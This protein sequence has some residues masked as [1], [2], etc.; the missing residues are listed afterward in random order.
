MALMLAMF[1]TTIS[2]QQLAFPGAQGWGRFAT[3]GRGGSV[4]HVTNL[5]DSGS[6]SLRDAVSQP[7]RIVVFDVAGVINIES[8][9][10]FMSNITVAGQTAPGDGITVYGDGTSCSGASNVIIRYMRFR[11]GSNA[12]SEDCGGLSNGQNMIFDHCSFSWAK[13]ENFSINWDN[14]GTK[15]QNITIQNSIIGQGLMQ[16]SAGGLIQ[17]CENITMYRNLLCDNKTRNFKVKG[18]HQYV[19]NIVYNWQSY[20]YEMGGESAG[21]SFANVEGNLFIN[22]PQ[23]SSSAN[24]FAG[25]N[26]DFHY[27]GNDNWQDRNKDGVFNPELFTG[28]GGGDPVSAP[29]DYPELEKWAGNTLIDNLLPDVGASLPY[30]DL[31]DA[32][33]VNE[34]L[35][36]G[37]EGA[38]I[39]KETLLPIG[40]PTSW[41]W[42]KGSKPADSDGDGMPDEWE[43][44]NGTN[45]NSNDAMTIA[46]NGYANIEN[47]INSITRTDRQYYLRAPMLLKMLTSTLNSL[48]ATW[49]DFSDNEEGFIIEMKKNGT[50]EEVGRTAAGVSSYT[51]A[52][53][54]LQPGT[55]YDIRVCAYSGPTKS[56][57]T[58]VVTMKT[59]P[60]QAEIVDAETFDGTGDGDWLIAPEEDET[61]TLGVATPKNTVVVRSD[62]HVTIDGSGYISG[63]ASLNKTG[64]GTLTIASNQQYEGPT[65]LHRGIYEFS[66]LK[67]GGVASGLGKSLEFAQNWVMDGGIYKYTGGNT[68]TNRSAKLSNDTELNIAQSGAVVTM[69]GSIE[70]TGNLEI[71]G[72]GRLT[73]NSE[74]FFKFDGNLV[75]SGSEV[76]LNSKA[77]SDAGIGSAKKLVLQG[78]KFTTVGMNESSATYNFPIEVVSGTTSTVDFDLWNTNKCSVSGT[79]TLVWNVHYLREYIEGNWDGF[80]GHLVVNG[81]GKANQSQFAV[82]NGAGVKN[83]TI[84][85]KGT[86]SITGGKNASTFYLGGLSGD[87]GTALSGFNVKAAG[88]GTWVVGGANTDETFNG[89]IDDYDQAHSHPGKTSIEKQGTGDWLLTGKNTY[90][91]TTVISGGRLIVN[92][93]HSGSGAITVKD[94]AT[95]AGTGTLMGNVKFENGSTL[96]ANS[97]VS[98]GKS[99]T[100][101][102]TVT[103]N[104]GV[105][106]KLGDGTINSASSGTTYQVFKGAAT[107]SFNS[108]IPETPGNGLK[109]DTSALYSSGV[110]K[111]IGEDEEPDAPDE[112]EPTVETYSALLSWNSMTSGS[113]DNNKKNRLTGNKGGTAEGFVMDLTGNA[114][115]EYGQYDQYSVEYN[116]GKVTANSIKTSNGAANTIYVPNGYEAT[117][118]TL[119]SVTNVATANRTSYWKTVAGTTYTADNATILQATKDTSKPAHVT[120]ALDGLTEIEFA[121]TGEQQCIIVAID[122]E[123]ARTLLDETATTAPSTVT[124]ANIRVKRTLNADEWSTIVLPFALSETQLKKLFGDAVQVADLTG[125]TKTDGGLNVNFQTVKAIEANHP[126]IIKVKNGVTQFTVNGV[127][128]TTTAQ[129]TYQATANATFAGTYVAETTIPSG[130]LFLSGN[131]F[132]YATDQ[133]MKSKGYRAW[134]DFD[135]KVAD[136]SRIT[137]TVDGTTAVNTVLDDGVTD[138]KVYNLQGISVKAPAKG[139]CIQNG[140]KVIIR[141]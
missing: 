1:T 49:S 102:G 47:Y 134:F 17:N 88:N 20:A 75:L 108:I 113:Y 106:L 69:S 33:M 132:W 10:V 105:T 107:G 138:G 120:F 53:Q 2:A 124:S 121:N 127:D 74:Q 82:R 122:Y 117:S 76:K 5:N 137:L 123:K 4:Y 100:F 19:N 68:S 31:A 96:Q 35:S 111:V 23:T 86:A 101:K 29:Y 109:W 34:V 130:C 115:K 104:N 99:L 45:P 46:T 42:F 135:D 59:H 30:R 60:E 14:K 84:E 39:T 36:F 11:M 44:A 50:F 119:W 133:T 26:S 16:H 55:G 65:V 67:D 140:K 21:E 112:S 85:L 93:T 95:L 32:Y 63:G 27:Y 64:N 3:G 103:L 90:S 56:E 54:D 139:I 37:T 116:G 58:A 48:T 13:D 118:I 77:I 78:G 6:G 129:P 22:G 38:L 9:L 66:T 131:K 126:Y 110:L 92:G 81:T 114:G 72:E 61:I 141:K 136:G 25:G 79:G 15:P 87:A 71:G 7:N 28:T 24:G 40:T 18:V 43:S 57:Y 83:A 70:G 52:D 125:Y 73:V 91:G 94:G 97:V 89:V 12:R 51:I 80:T 62:A 128:I 98:N 8:H 41:S